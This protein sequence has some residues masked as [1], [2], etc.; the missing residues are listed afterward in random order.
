MVLSGFEGSIGLGEAPTEGLRLAG[1]VHDV[2]KLTV[3]AEILNKPSLL[4][5][6]EFELIKGH[7]AAGYEILASIDFDYPIADIVVQHHER[8]DGS[9]Y[10]AGLG[11]ND[12]LPEARI[13]A[14][15]D[16]VEAMASHRPYRPALGIEAALAEIRAGAG[17]RYDSPAVDACERLFASGFAFEE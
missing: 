15:A 16:V 11:G 5:P 9:G 2:G 8:M 14:V 17:T 7:S 1:L 13:L 3:P 12:I 4:T 6:V 10:P